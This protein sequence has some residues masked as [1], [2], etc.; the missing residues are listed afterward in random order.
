[1]VITK[2]DEELMNSNLWVDITII[3]LQER[4]NIF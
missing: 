2:L 4:V 1:M 3:K